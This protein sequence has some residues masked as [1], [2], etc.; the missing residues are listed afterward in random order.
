MNTKGF[1]MYLSMRKGFSLAITLWLSTAL[2]AGAIYFISI[3][4]ENVR[5]SHQLLNKLQSSIETQE[6]LALLKYAIAS[7]T[8]DKNII[9]NHTISLLPKKLP[10]D[11]TP[12]Q[13]KHTTIQLQDTGGLINTMYAQYLVPET[14]K[15]FYPNRYIIAKN[16]LDDWL[17]TNSFY[18]LNG[19]EKSYYQEQGRH[20]TPRNQ[21]YLYHSDEL[22]NIR[23]FQDIPFEKSLIHT[24]HNGYNPYTMSSLILQA[25][26][27][28]SKKEADILIHLRQE[29]LESF[30]KKLVK[31]KQKLHLDS[32]PELT[33]SKIIR[34][35]LRTT[36]QKATTTITAIIDFQTGTNLYLD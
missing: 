18:R 7:G 31:F 10:I 5:I 34:I 3:N 22:Y 28:L 20:Y 19:A 21:N 33:Y 25:T 16:S 2:I 13:Y 9:Q 12:F 14:L 24:I 15:L 8:F 36:Y 1:N 30:R 29:N 23:G 4:K 6:T 32:L 11:S 35:T 27:H 26:Y 17:D